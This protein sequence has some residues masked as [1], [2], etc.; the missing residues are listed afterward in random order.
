MRWRR[1]RKEREADLER[2]LR[3]HL[4][5][6]AEEQGLPDEEAAYAARRALGNA[7]VVKEQVRESWGWTRFEQ[8]IRDL[9]YSLRTLR[10]SPGFTLTAVL[11]LALG[12]GANTAIFTVV[13]AVLLRPLPFP[14]P[15][16]LVQLWEAKPSKGY[17]DNVINPLNFLDWRD[18][19]HSFAGMAAVLPIITN[20]TG[21]G[22]PVALRGMQV[23]PNYFSIL[24]VRPV[25]GR[26]FLPEEGTPG[27]DRVTILSF[28]LW[29][30]RF[31]GDTGVIGRKLMVNGEPSIVVGVMPRGFTMPKYRAEIWNPMTLVR[32]EGAGR[33]RYLQAIARLKDGIPLE[34]AQQ[35]LQRVAHQLAAERPDFDAGWTAEAVPMLADATAKVRLPLLVLLA[36]VALV[37]MIACANVAN[38]LLMRAAGRRQEM[39]VR[40]ALG[41]GRRRLLQQLLSETFILAG[42]ACLI[43]LAI[44][45]GGVKGLLALIPDQSHLPRLDVVAMDARVFLFAAALS[46][47]SAL[48]FGLI[49]SLQVSQIRP[50]QTLSSAS[51]RLTARSSFRR[52]LVVLEIALALVL[53]AGAGLMLRS[54]QKLISVDPG[55]S[56]ERV[57]T[58]T[59][60]TSP[61]RYQ[62]DQKR[63]GYFANLLRE[64]RSV[65]GVQEAGSVHFLPL[66]N[67]I[68]GSCFSRSDEPPPVP[69]KARDSQFLVVSP[70]YFEA[71]K[72][73]LLAGRMF[74]TRDSFGKPNVVM[75]NRQFVKKFLSD[76]NPVGQKLNVCWTVQNPVEIV[77]VVA[78]ARQTE[79]GTAPK[80]TIF[81]DNLQ[82]PMYFAEIVVRTAGDPEGT[83][84]AVERAIHRVDPDQAL[85]H[86]GTL[87]Q[88][89]SDSVAQPRMQLV[90]L[91]VFGGLAGLLAIVGVYGVVSYS[92]AQR[93][94][95]IGIRMALGAQVSEVG[96]TV[97][98]EGLLLAIAGAALGLAGALALTRLMRTLLFEI[99][100]TDTLTLASVTGLLLFVVVLATT[101]PAYRAA[102]TDPISTLRYE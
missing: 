80:P 40:A 68:S 15:H 9:R 8:F 55:F 92:V 45:Y 27:K 93:A 17:S 101:M 34:Q 37:L 63:A 90:L 22:E 69:S 16:R 24:G 31:G 78:D 10:R 6:E 30:S 50:Q 88:V 54:F 60:F 35:D 26:A 47:A 64:I 39:A 1:R 53:L 19:A 56:I 14:Q 58:F 91:L 44:A 41:A 25:I 70:G 5:A 97:L 57:L 49:P 98:R 75:V 12:I 87:A 51:A 62:N 94:R 96:F 46:I 52:A 38:L 95:E 23:S 32:S 84:G 66:M 74:D 36:A 73:P 72:I 7:G 33:G 76:R 100:P 67:S 81:I 13:N 2:E 48:L 85:T 3:T 102:Q 11:S 21:A 18:R 83:L 29:R 89:F 82:A 28:G 59:L 43:G 99:P 65:P 86:I 4:E 42:A 61:A 79:L 77:G 71:L 20:V